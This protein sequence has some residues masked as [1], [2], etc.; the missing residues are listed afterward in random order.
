[1]ISARSAASARPQARV[2]GGIGG[3]VTC[4]WS[5]LLSPPARPASRLPPVRRPRLPKESTW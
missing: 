2:R 1:M 4:C 5:P 3:A